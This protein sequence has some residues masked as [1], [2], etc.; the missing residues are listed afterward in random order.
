MG[1]ITVPQYD[2]GHPKN[3]DYAYDLAR[4]RKVDMET[5]RPMSEFGKHI[6][7]TLTIANEAAR[8]HI[9]LGRQQFADEVKRIAGRAEP[10]AVAQIMD[11][12]ERELK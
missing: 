4:Q 6:A 3:E 7:E 10:T 9:R 2:Y 11:L 5:A 8:I 12:C 1:S